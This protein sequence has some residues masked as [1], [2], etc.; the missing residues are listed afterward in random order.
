MKIY[1]HENGHHTASLGHGKNKVKATAPTF[2]EAM[3]ECGEA[4]EAKN[5]QKN[6][7]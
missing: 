4:A 2:L 3:I 7:K 6:C 1:Q 5:K